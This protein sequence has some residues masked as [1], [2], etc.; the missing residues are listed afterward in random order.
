MI[1]EKPESETLPKENGGYRVR[2]SDLWIM[3]PS[4]YRL[5]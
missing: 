5:S 3:I 2:T 4:L 1:A